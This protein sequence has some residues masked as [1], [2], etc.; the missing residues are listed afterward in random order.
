MQLVQ[1]SQACSNALQAC[2]TKVDL[3]SSGTKLS[4]LAI[5]HPDETHVDEF[6][7]EIPAAA[8]E[9]II[10][11]DSNTAVSKNLN[12]AC[13]VIQ[14]HRP[15]TGDFAA[16]RN[17]ALAFCT[18][19]WVLALDAD[20]RLP[21]KSWQQVLEI[22]NQNEIEACFLPRLTLYPNELHF[23]A[24]F[25]LWPDPQLR[26]FKKTAQTQFN[27][28]IHEVLQGV[29]GSQALLLHAPILH[30]S[31][32][33]KNRELLQQRL[34]VFNQAAGREA[35]RLNQEYPCLPMAWHDQF[36]KISAPIKYL[37]LPRAV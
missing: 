2:E 17:Y 8:K 12:C 15:L 4:I 36:Q 5:F 37:V 33:L 22:T 29:E 23:R 11:W 34:A 31:Y 21:P 28:P 7:A 20:E 30:Y 9:L 35:H 16:Q 24:G 18:A 6:C 19:P 26:L 32:I 3:N 25:G 14:K 13:P 1:H 10:V 27:R